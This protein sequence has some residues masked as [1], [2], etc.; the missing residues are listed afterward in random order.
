MTEGYLIKKTRAS[1]NC[2]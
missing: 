2:S 1:I